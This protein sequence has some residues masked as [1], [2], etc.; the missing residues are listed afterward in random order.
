MKTS[1]I[2][3]AILFIFLGFS[4]NEIYKDLTE[5]YELP[6]LDYDKY[7][8]KGP[9]KPKEIAVNRLIISITDQVSA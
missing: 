8:G 6:E 7:W 3:T 4:F 9:K 1:T 5:E 2:F